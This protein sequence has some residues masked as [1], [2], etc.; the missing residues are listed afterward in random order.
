MI[1]LPSTVRALIGKPWL[2]RS[3]RS[4]ARLDNKTIIV[5]GANTGIGK[6]AAAEFA[7]RG[8]RV[9]LACRSE[10]KGEAA[11]EDIRRTC[12]NENVVFKKLDLASFKSIREFAQDINENEKSLDILVNNAGLVVSRTLTE[13]GLEMIMGVNHFGHFLLTNLLLDKIKQTP[14]ARIVVVA[15]H[16]YSLVRHINF[17]DIQNEKDF[18][19]INVYCQSKLANVYFTRS[20]AKRLESH[21]VIVNTLHP[22]A[23]RTDIWRNMYTVVKVITYP[24]FLLLFKSC[25][26]GAQ[27][28]IHL[29][30]SEEVEGITGQYFENCRQ[31]PLKPHALDDEVAER[32]WKV[33]EEITGLSPSSTNAL[34]SSTNASPSS[35][36]ASP[37]SSTAI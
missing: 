17:D 5:T 23:V 31:V 27:T 12:N 28:T 26:Q 35:T 8:G 32:L 13:D 24:F 20:L 7:R 1:D 18:S 4:E 37:S 14:K 30:I 9:I 11:A 36:N 25:K 3:C 15:S 21:G 10:S 16:G 22:G 33:S 34:P 19:S 29:A 2:V 6:E